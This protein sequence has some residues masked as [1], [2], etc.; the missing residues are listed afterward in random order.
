M[1]ELTKALGEAK[2]TLVEF[3]SAS[4]PHCVAMNPVV[5]ELKADL[6]DRANIIQV[7]VDTADATAKQYN[8]RTVPTWLLFKDGQEVWRD[9]GRK[10]LSEL[11]DMVRRFI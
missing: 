8:V 6:G 11:K 5:D 7:D 1:N 10:P 4:C 9:G 3:Y 2:P